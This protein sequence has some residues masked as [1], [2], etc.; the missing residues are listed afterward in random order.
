M[1]DLQA[2]TFSQERYRTKSQSSVERRVDKQS[3]ETRFRQRK[4]ELAGIKERK[5]EDSIQG[6]GPSDR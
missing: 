1:T 2:R 4:P 6:L 5:V 3:R